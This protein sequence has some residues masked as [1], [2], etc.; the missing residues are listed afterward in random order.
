MEWPS[1]YGSSPPA[2]IVMITGMDMKKLI[3][4]N[5]ACSMRVRVAGVT[6][7]LAAA[8]A[9]V[10]MNGPAAGGVRGMRDR[11]SVV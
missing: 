5:S 1:L 4:R 11:K 6:L 9:A 7:I 2:T 8:T 10:A 3:T